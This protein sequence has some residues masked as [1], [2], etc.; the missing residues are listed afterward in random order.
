MQLHNTHYSI[1]LKQVSIKSLLQPSR[2]QKTNEDMI[3][4]TN[5]IKL[6][7]YFDSLRFFRRI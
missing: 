1:Y 6:M 5:R 7:I 4:D 2:L 3:K